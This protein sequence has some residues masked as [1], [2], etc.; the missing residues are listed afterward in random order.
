MFFRLG[1]QYKEV[2]P[3]K[4]KIWEDPVLASKPD[5]LEVTV[6]FT[7]QNFPIKLSTPK[8]D[9]IPTLGEYDQRKSPGEF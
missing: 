9:N 7:P 8:Y 4:W 3:S 2:I 6:T 5:H 1:Y